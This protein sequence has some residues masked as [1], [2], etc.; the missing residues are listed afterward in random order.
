MAD[1]LADS[2]STGKVRIKIYSFAQQE[3]LLVLD[4][5]RWHLFWALGH[6][7]KVEIHAPVDS[8]Q[9]ALCTY[10]IYM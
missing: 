2:L 8:W 9:A 10:A 4:M 1:I 6:S 7:Y 3:N 5:T